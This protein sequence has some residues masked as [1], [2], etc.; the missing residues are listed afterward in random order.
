M[1]NTTQHRCYG[2]YQREQQSQPV[3]E[4]NLTLISSLTVVLGLSLVYFAQPKSSGDDEY[5][6]AR[7]GKI[8]QGVKLQMTIKTRFGQ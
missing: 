8:G 2:R 3:G 6:K 4:I 7:N 1:T 5:N